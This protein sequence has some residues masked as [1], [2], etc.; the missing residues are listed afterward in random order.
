MIV[1][2]KVVFSNAGIND[3]IDNVKECNFSNRSACPLD[4]DCIYKTL[5]INALFELKRNKNRY[6]GVTVD[7][8]KSRWPNHIIVL[9]YR[10]KT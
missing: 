2:V 9:R 8:F 6:V 1:V 4:N 7:L 3:I 5:Y 10:Q